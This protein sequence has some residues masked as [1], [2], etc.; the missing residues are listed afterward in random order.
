MKCPFILLYSF[1]YRYIYLFSVDYFSYSA[2]IYKYNYSCIK[3]TFICGYI[4]AFT[5][6]SDED[7]Y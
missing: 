6:E 4:Y 2:Q 7:M 5:N 1:N 3:Y